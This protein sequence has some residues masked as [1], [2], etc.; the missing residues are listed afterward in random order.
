MAAAVA[1]SPATCCLRLKPLSTAARFLSIYR[2]Y[3]L[4]PS[5][6][7]NIP[8]FPP[9]PLAFSFS[10]FPRQFTAAALPSSG[11]AVL[12][13]DT[14]ETLKVGK[15]RKR[16]RVLDIKGGPDEGLD[17]LGQH[18][19]VKGWVRTLRLQ[20]SVTFIEVFPYKLNF[21]LK[22]Y[23]F[24]LSLL[25]FIV[26]WM[27]RWMMV[28]VFQICNVL[29]VRMPKVMMRYFF[30]SLTKSLCVCVCVWCFLGYLKIVFIMFLV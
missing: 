15:F 10:S 13:Q 26:T 16:V 27:F 5:S 7:I 14:E 28:L 11:E 9:K 29:W 3:H 18:F 20:S 12:K 21:I 2:H 25:W 19:V 22:C 1:L 30:Y 8:L 23:I 24:C 6:P 17:K 4:L